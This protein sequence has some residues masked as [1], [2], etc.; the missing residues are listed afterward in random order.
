MGATEIRQY[1]DFLAKDRQ[2][3]ASTQNQA[4]NAIVFLYAQVLG[5]EPG[6][7][8]DFIRARRPSTSAGGTHPTGSCFLTRSTGRRRWFNGGL[9]LRGR[10]VNK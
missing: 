7:F 5:Q 10:A 2:V 6:D 1:L 4:L 3:A 9:A 8:Q